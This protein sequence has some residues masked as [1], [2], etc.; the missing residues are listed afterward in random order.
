M[1]LKSA[2]LSVLGRDA[3]KEITDG[4]GIDGA[5]RRS[6]EDMAAALSSAH[7]ATA[8]AILGFLYESEVKAACE[9]FGI[10]SHGR[11]EKLIRA[12]ASSPTMH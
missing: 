6:A 8:E 10:S 11:K 9:E 7:R 12:F 1:K 2:I 3:L 4:L 5:D